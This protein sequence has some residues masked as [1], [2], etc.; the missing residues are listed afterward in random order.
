MFSIP[1][2]GR[3]ATGDPEICHDVFP[4]PPVRRALTRWTSPAWL[5]TLL[6]AWLGAT[7]GD[8]SRGAGGDDLVTA[9]T[10]ALCAPRN[11]VG[12]PGPATLCL[13]RPAPPEPPVLGRQRAEAQPPPP[14]RA[15]PVAGARGPR[16]PPRLHAS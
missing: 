1:E 2:P 16:A 6:V 8:A 10:K 4:M 15:C 13:A 12:D 14:P 9:D 11:S 3:P 7:P 5:A